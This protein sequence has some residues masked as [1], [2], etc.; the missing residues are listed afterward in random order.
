MKVTITQV[1]EYT[2]KPSLYPPGF[3]PE[4]MVEMD[5]DNGVCDYCE[6][7]TT[8]YEITDDCGS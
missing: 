3:T 7:W 8:T 4:E 6:D 2:L 1:M 5:L